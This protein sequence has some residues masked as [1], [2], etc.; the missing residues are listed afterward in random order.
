MLGAIGHEGRTL[1]VSAMRHGDD[2][3]LAGDEVF[4]L[5]VAAAIHD[6]GTPGNGEVG[7]YLQEFVT[8]DA[9]EEFTGLQYAEQ[10]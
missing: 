1:D 5:E 4:I 8:D 7:L 2:H 6:L 9:H 3:V 10:V